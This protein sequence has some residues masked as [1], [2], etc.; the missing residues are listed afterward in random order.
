MTALRG[1]T[2]L[3]LCQTLGELAARGLGL[4]LPGPVLGM[5]LLLGALAWPVLRAP[6]QAAAEVL[7]A[8]LSL[9]FVP[10]GV[11]VVAH[12]GMLG[13]HAPAIAV[14]LLLST[15]IG[16][17]VTALVLRALWRDGAAG[18]PIG[19]SAEATVDPTSGGARP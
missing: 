3:L 10:I 1:F 18:A 5:L 16:L 2:V 8:H 17:A 4:S 14:T 11:G 7:L 6:V 19:A 12:L 13:E 9:L 15:W